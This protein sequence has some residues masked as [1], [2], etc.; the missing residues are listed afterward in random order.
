MTV[1]VLCAVPRRVWGA[2]FGGICV[3]W[4]E[5]KEDFEG[6]ELRTLESDGSLKA[7]RA[8]GPAFDL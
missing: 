4:E 6:G 7:E 1:D 3:N 8:F 5:P 2:R